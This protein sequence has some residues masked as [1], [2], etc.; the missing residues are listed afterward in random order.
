MSISEL[1]TAVSPKLG[2]VMGNVEVDTQFLKRLGLVVGSQEG[3]SETRSVKAVLQLC[4]AHCK[5]T[6]GNSLSDV[7]ILELTKASEFSP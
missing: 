6:E 7:K 3:S 5:D 4:V 1:R 2:Q